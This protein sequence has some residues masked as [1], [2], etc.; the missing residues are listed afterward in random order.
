MVQQE[1]CFLFL[2]NAFFTTL[3][4]INLHPQIKLNRDGVKSNLMDAKNTTGSNLLFQNE[5]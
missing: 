1:L 5:K 2:T 4:E 3:S